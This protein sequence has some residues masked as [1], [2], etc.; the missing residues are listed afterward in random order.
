MEKCKCGSEDVK[1]EERI[2]RGNPPE[3]YQPPSLMPKPKISWKGIWRIY[4]C[5]KCGNTWKKFKR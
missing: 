3:S 1:Y 4:T 5:N 2:G